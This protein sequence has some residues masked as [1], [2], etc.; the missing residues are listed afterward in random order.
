MFAEKTLE[1]LQRFV[2]ERHKGVT[3]HASKELGIPN[4]TLDKRY[5]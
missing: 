4:D 1:L 3:L 2:E 5:Q